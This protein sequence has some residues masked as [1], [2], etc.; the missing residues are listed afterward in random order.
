M[1]PRKSFVIALAVALLAGHSAYAAITFFQA[2]ASFPISPQPEFMAVADMNRDGLEDV[3][4]ISPQSDEVNILLSFP[5]QPSRFSPVAVEGFGSTLRRGTA[6]DVTR[7]GIP[8]LIVPDQRQDGVWVLV[9]NGEGRVT[10]PSFFPVGRNPYAVAV[11]D[12][13]GVR[14]NDIAVSDQR[15]GSVTILLNDGGSPPRFTR[16]PI[17]AVGEQPLTILAIDVNGDDR[18]DLVT[19]NEGGPRVKSISVLT[20]L[21]VTAGL[22]VFAPAQNFGVG[23]RPSEMNSADLNDDGFDDIVML[24][25]PT[26]G[27]NS[28]I[29]VLMSRGTGIF[30]GPTAFEVPCPFFTGG[31]TCRSHALTVGDFDG[32]GTIDL[33]VFLTDPRRV[34][35]GAGIE[36]DALIIYGGRGDGQFAQGPV[37]RTPKSPLAA[38]AV[39]INGDELVDLAAGFRRNTNIT[40]FINASTPG[41]RGNGEP[42]VVGGECLSGICVEGFCCASACADNESCAVLR[43]EGICTRVPDIVVPCDF[44]DQCF[45]IPNEGDPGTC[46][47]GFCCEERCPEGRCDIA[48][49]EGLCIPTFGPGALCDDERDCSTGFCVDDRCCL[50]A[51]LNGFCGGDDG[52]CRP[53]LGLGEPCDIDG[54]CET[55]I[56]DRFTG[57]CCGDICT[58]DEECNDLG[59][60]VAANPTPGLGELGDTCTTDNDCAN[61]QCVNDVCCTVA[62]CPSG[63]VCQ[64]PNGE[65]APEPTPTPTPIPME[66]GTSCTQPEQCVSGFCV[67]FVCCEVEECEED[68]FCSG[69]A[70]G[71]CVFG[72]PP[73]TPTPTPIEVCRD[74][75]CAEGRVCIE[76][77]G[78][79]ECVDECNGGFCAPDESCVPEAGGGETCVDSCRDVQCRNGETCVIGNSGAPVC[80]IPCGVGTFCEPGETCQQGEIGQP[81]CIRST[82]SGGC[83]VEQGASTADLW[84]LALLPLALWIL[85]RNELPRRAVIRISTRK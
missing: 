41:E 8:D 64:P 47:D 5:E 31:A 46:V 65:C 62:E 22:P 84:V 19:L 27:G 43:R 36:N 1:S 11:A 15:L 77:D 54:Q 6:A 80:A 14:G 56:C 34:G 44:D 79:G 26:G 4:V 13:D 49:L 61:Q 28:Q 67:D 29:N 60:C 9:G 42:C 68:E 30:D 18:M 73:A 10:N 53:P 58:D 7:D 39:D 69:S 83:A 50:E 51:C 21:R 52:V 45:D 74:V 70:G 59:E 24:N 3:I 2:E 57:V 75:P 17:F 48:G 32:N 12:F 20:F 38:V 78:R 16:G 63:E 55:E 35:T 76:I 82:R 25:R 66:N 37:L 33:A 71:M 81:L 23:E 85:R 40:A 72:T